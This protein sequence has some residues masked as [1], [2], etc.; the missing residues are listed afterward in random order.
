VHCHAQ[1]TTSFDGEAVTITM[2]AA[3]KPLNSN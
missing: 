2:L 1:L 3:L